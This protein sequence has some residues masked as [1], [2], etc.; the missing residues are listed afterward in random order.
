M[1]PK[2]VHYCWLSGDKLPASFQK[3][4]DNW[5]RLMPD[6]EFVLWDM[7]RFESL[8]SNCSSWVHKCFELKRYAWAA[9]PI[10]LIALYQYG[11][12]YMDLDVEM[13]KPFDELLESDYILGYEYTGNIEAGI[14]ATAPN[15]KWLKDCI[16]YYDNRNP[17][18]EDGSFDGY[19][20]PNIISDTLFGK[21]YIYHKR[22]SDE[23]ICNSNDIKELFLFPM[24]YLSAKDGFW[25][26]IKKSSN[27]YTIHHFAASSTPLKGHIRRWI[28]Q[29]LGERVVNFLIR[30]KRQIF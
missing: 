29:F 21:G 18:K 9:D 12:I 14:M 25:N 22:E 27:T 13:V 10:R 30:V 8:N 3:N 6:Y 11:G 16:S 15:L 1:I 28:F 4:L 26:K 5:K 7:K 23:P 17:V 2:I 24:D 19:P 20:L